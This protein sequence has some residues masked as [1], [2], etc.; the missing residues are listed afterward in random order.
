MLQISLQ[1]YTKRLF[2][3]RNGFCICEMWR[4]ITSKVMADFDSFSQFAIYTTYVYIV[5]KLKIS[6][7]KYSTKML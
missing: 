3:H 7:S 1:K 5:R 4:A 2:T 6:I